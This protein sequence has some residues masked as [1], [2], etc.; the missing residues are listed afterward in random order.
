MLL[1]LQGSVWWFQTDKDKANFGKL[2]DAIKESK[3]GKVIGVYSKDKFPG[4]FNES[5]RAALKEAN[6]ET[7]S[8]SPLM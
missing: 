6:F 8:N 4:E 5:W 3:K 7:V 1:F 2:I